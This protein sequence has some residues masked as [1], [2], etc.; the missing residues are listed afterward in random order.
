MIAHTLRLCANAEQISLPALEEQSSTAPNLALPGVPGCLPS[1][2][3]SLDIA[4]RPLRALFPAVGTR[5]G[6]GPAPLPA[7]AVPYPA[8]SQPHASAARLRAAVL[9]CRRRR[10]DEDGLYPPFKTSASAQQVPGQAGDL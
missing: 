5:P 7:A 10:T 1:P 9:S 2:K 3:T 6:I 4:A 8:L